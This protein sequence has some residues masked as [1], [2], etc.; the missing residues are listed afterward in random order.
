MKAYKV[1]S[2][3]ATFILNLGTRCRSVVNFT[4]RPR[5]YREI[6]PVPIEY[7]AGCGRL[8]EE[9]NLLPLPEFEARIIQPVA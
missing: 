8:G 3:T 7:K 6:T 9:I 1:S 5:Y 4:I 2:V